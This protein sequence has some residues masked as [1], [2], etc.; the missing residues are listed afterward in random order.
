MLFGHSLLHVDIG[1]ELFIV[2]VEGH[3]NQKKIVRI[4]LD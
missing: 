3:R 4:G 1:W 2:R